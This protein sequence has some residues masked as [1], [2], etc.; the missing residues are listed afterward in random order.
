MLVTVVQQQQEHRPVRPLLQTQES[1][2][3]RAVQCCDGVLLVLHQRW[4]LRYCSRSPTS[5]GSAGYPRT[6]L[7]FLM[8]LS[9]SASSRDAASP[10]DSSEQD[11][12]CHHHIEANTLQFILKLCQK[13]CRF[14]S[15]YFEQR[16]SKCS[17]AVFLILCRP[18]GKKQTEI[19][20]FLC[21]VEFWGVY[22]V[23]SAL[24]KRRTV[25][26]KGLRWFK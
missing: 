24:C 3:E 4:P 25:A 19:M 15:V 26:E 2:T 1:V 10:A 9:L 14:K 8:S 21:F 23:L 16:S 12:W 18:G 6:E 5:T 17:G 7:V 11:G 20:L 22:A 13:R